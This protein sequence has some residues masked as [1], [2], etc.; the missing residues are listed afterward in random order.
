MRRQPTVLFVTHDLREALSLAQRIVFLSPSP[1]RIVSEHLVA[2]CGLC[3]T[4][5]PAVNADYAALLNQ[6][7]QLLQGL[8]SPD[9]ATNR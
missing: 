1:A 7:A 9:I 4:D 2:R 5:D 8:H 6:Y 3:S